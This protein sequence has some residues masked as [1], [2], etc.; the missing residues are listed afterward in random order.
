MKLIKILGAVVVV[1]VVVLLIGK[2]KGWFGGNSGISVETEKVAKRDISETVTASGKIYPVNEVKISAEI[3]GEI[4]EM[5]VW[6][7]DKVKAGQLLLRINPDLY[8]SQV[9][10]AEAAVNNSKATLA[11]ARSRVLQAEVSMENATTAYNRSKKL[12]ADKVISSAEFEQA[13]LAYKTTKAEL[14]ISKESVTA[15]EYTVKSAEATLR[16]MRDNYKRTAIY[17]PINGTVFGMS[18]KAGEK[19]LGTI[20][21]T[22]DVLM[23]IAN[24]SE[25]EVQVDV[26]ENDVL[27]INIGDTADIEVDAYLDRKFTGVVTQIAN[28]AAGAGGLLAVSNEQATNFKV[29]VRILPES[30]TDLIA[31]NK[32]PFFPGMSATTE[33]RTRTE[34]DVL[35]VPIQAVTTREDTTLANSELQILVFTVEKDSVVQRNVKTGIQDDKYI[36]ILEGLKEG[37]TIVSGPYNTVATI[38]K[39]GDLVKVPESE[40]AEEKK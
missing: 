33:I 11:S 26:S 22:G 1:L 35:T 15:M 9:E 5:A 21:M 7:G 32:Y 19:V 31:D 23:S 3:S 27:R 37:E 6:E 13:E 29:K 10:Q 34:K 18:K 40:T 20:Q 38:L 24:L 8:E 14:E 28:S 30:Y 17:A 16:Q 36:Q 39:A 25:M 12:Y 2:N 4:V